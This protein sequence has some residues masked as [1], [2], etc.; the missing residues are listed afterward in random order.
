MRIRSLSPYV[1]LSRPRGTQDNDDVIVLLD[2]LE[3]HL[4]WPGQVNRPRRTKM[5]GE[6]TI[7]LPKGDGYGVLPPSAL[8][9]VTCQYYREEL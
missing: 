9:V 3:Q 5:P 8:E 4:Q 2:I 7:E 1:T 6:D